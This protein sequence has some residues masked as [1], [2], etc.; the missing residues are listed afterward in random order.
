MNPSVAATVAGDL[1]TVWD[2]IA[3]V[4]ARCRLFRLVPVLVAGMVAVA[5][6]VDES[7]LVEKIDAMIPQDLNR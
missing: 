2:R 3:A 7:G 4:T 1:A 6:M 5:G